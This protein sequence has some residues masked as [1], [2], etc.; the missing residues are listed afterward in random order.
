M[1]E[2]TFISRNGKNKPIFEDKA[3]IAVS[4]ISK[5]SGVVQVSQKKLGFSFP[6]QEQ[7]FMGVSV[8]RS[9]GKEHK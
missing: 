4:K 9:Q 2:S 6:L 7:M 1:L 5:R 8:A 3:F